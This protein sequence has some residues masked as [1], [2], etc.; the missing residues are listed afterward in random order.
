MFIE[1]NNHTMFYYEKTNKITLSICLYLLEIISKP[2]Q[3]KFDYFLEMLV[4]NVILLIK[5]VPKRTKRTR[6]TQICWPK[7]IMKLINYQIKEK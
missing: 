6:R 3:N 7:T 4:S 1:E 5:L 2:Q